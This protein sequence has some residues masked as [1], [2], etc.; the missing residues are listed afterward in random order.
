MK[1]VL[2][3]TILAS[4]GLTGSAAAWTFSQTQRGAE[5]HDLIVAR[6][7]GA[8]TNENIVAYVDQLG[9]R[10][11]AETEQ[12]D[13]GW[14]FTVLDNATV[15]AFAQ[16]GGYIYVTR[17]LLAFANDEAEL[18]G[19]LAHQ[20]AHSLL[21]N[22]E[23][24]PDVTLTPDAPLAPG[25]RLDGLTV[26]ETTFDL[27]Q[28]TRRALDGARPIHTPEMQAAAAAKSVEI[29]N[30]AGYP[31]SS[32][33][34]FAERLLSQ[35]ALARVLEG[36]GEV[37][38][39]GATA[40]AKAQTVAA[41]EAAARAE[42]TDV[43]SADY[44]SP[45]LSVIRGLTY[46]ESPTQGMVRDGRFVHPALGIAFDIPRGFTSEIT[47]GEMIARGPNGATLIL[48]TTDAASLR[49]DSYLRDTWAPALTRAVASGYLYDLA[50]R[51]IGGFDAASAFL[52]YEDDA[53]PKV[54][55]LVTIKTEQR[56]YRFRA[57]SA[58]ADFETALRMEEAI[59]SFRPL[60]PAVSASVKPYWIHVH[61]IGEGDSV[62]LFA[63]AMPIRENPETRFRALNGYP[64][65]RVPMVGELVKLVME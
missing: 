8:Y 6:H 19:V 28:P 2:C 25:G 47:A 27:P 60:P 36:M 18:A 7:G 54:V 17:G 51:E 64:D 16:P 43:V 22:F 9:R 50:T 34:A 52:P 12:A 23:D 37:E 3:A 14:Q 15:S 49:L 29:L 53:G 24:P 11:A 1:S 39:L 38:L 40:E 21:D 55:Q 56:T 13:Q 30:E 33:L 41:I 48:D 10:L 5:A 59:N 42:V 45:Y 20:A 31:A 62:N 44:A 57:I 61:R 58:A 26:A 46:G 4:M 65:E 35:E 32:Y 63:A